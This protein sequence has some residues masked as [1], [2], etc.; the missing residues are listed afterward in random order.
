M[1]RFAKT[2]SQNKKHFRI[3]EEAA[4]DF[5]SVKLVACNS[6]WKFIRLVF[7]NHFREYFDARN[8]GR[9]TGIKMTERV[10]V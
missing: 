7:F 6:S 8:L 3:S 1:E 10:T 5:Y 2:Y 9:K 4:L